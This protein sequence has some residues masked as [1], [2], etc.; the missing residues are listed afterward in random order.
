MKNWQICIL[1]SMLLLV[2]S[3]T[4]SAGVASFEF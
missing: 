1:L 3:G 4:A 2:L